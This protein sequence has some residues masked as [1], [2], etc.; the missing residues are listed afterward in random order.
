MDFQEPQGIYQQ[1]ANHLCEEILRGV[2][3]VDARIP[4][5]REMAV[6]ISVNPNTVLR[7]YTHL[8]ESGVL[9]NRRGIGFFVDANARYRIID[10]KRRTFLER[11]LPQ[12]FRQLDLLHISIDEVTSRYQLHRQQSESA[13]T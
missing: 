13:P 6:Q 1:I 12:V 10:L 2:W 3:M 11:D 8:E 5:V 4:S 7:A 9:Y